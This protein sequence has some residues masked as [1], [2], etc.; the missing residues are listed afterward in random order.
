MIFIFYALASYN[1][2]WGT[3]LIRPAGHLFKIYKRPQCQ[4]P[5]IASLTASMMFVPH[6]MMFIFPPPFMDIVF[7]FDLSTQLVKSAS[8]IPTRFYCMVL[9]SF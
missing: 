1:F 8:F 6:Y 7:L 5:S 3:H 2:R 4:F 9:H